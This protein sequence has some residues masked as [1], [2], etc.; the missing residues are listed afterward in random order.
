[1]YNIMKENT[2]FGN[3]DVYNFIVLVLEIM[4]AFKVQSDR[5]WA[6]H[7]GEVPRAIFPSH[8]SKCRMFKC[9]KLLNHWLD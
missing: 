4:Q 9:S 3:F 5:L 2:I 8:F 1:M 6:V 7:F